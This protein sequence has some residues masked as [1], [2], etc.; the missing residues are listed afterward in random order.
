VPPNPELRLP[1]VELHRQVAQELRQAEQE[2]RP[3]VALPPHRTVE[4]PPDAGVNPMEATL[5]APPMAALSE[6]APM[7]AVPT[8]TTPSAEWIFITV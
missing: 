8:S 7:E 6:P 4:E 1:G 3:D 5:L 2:P